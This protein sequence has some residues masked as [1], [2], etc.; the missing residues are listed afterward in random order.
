MLGVRQSTFS[1]VQGVA[2]LRNTLFSLSLLL[3]NGPPLQLVEQ[4]I[5]V[6]GVR[7]GGIKLFPLFH[8]YPY[9]FSFLWFELSRRLKFC[10]PFPSSFLPSFFLE[11]RLRLITLLSFGNITSLGERPKESFGI[12]LRG[13]RQSRGYTGKKRFFSGSRFF[14][15]QRFRVPFFFSTFQKEWLFSHHSEINDTALRDG[16]SSNRLLLLGPKCLICQW[17][18]VRGGGFPSRKNKK[19]F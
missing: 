17:F 19:Q 8:S 2:T 12:F 15:I 18:P 6:T 11:F 13:R 16:V 14:P 9:G 4:K 10:L 3:F 7:G 1:L 5:F